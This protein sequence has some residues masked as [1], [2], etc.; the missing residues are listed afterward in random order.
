MVTVIAKKIPQSKTVTLRGTGVTIQFDNNGKSA[1]IPPE[2]FTKAV[3]VYCKV[4]RWEWE[5]LDEK[6]EE[7]TVEKAVQ[8]T[9][10]ELK[11]A[12]L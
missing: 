8:K 6:K 5:G 9:N 3:Q 2:R 7:N 4:N 10:K 1:P 11:N 12:N